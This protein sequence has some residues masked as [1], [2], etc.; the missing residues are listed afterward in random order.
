MNKIILLGT[1]MVLF[2]ACSDKNKEIEPK[3]EKTPELNTTKELNI[4]KEL[5]SSKANIMVVPEEFIPEH[6]RHSTI[7]VVEH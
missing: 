7:E 2:V 5:N 4:T 6:I 3:I 1:L